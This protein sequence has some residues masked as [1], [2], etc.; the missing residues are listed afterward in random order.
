MLQ[1][2]EAEPDPARQ[3][4]TKDKRPIVGFRLS[5][6]CANLADA[7][8]PKRMPG[9]FYQF[10]FSS[11]PDVACGPTRGRTNQACLPPAHH[12][13]A[14]TSWR[15]SSV[16]TRLEPGVAQPNVTSV[17]VYQSS[18]NEACWP[19]DRLVRFESAPPQ[20][21]HNQP[22]A[23]MPTFLRRTLFDPVQPGGAFSI[24]SSAISA[25]ATN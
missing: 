14:K 19:T 8:P 10:F 18:D 5:C 11:S 4:H 7:P 22:A 13:P 1:E 17:P 23:A 6:T 3:R 2:R 21:S 9:A 24:A 25:L 16:G 12:Q 15:I 20:Q